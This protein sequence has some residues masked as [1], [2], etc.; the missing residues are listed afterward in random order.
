M[1]SFETYAHTKIATGLAI[2]I[3]TFGVAGCGSSDNEKNEGQVQAINQTMPA[4]VDNTPTPNESPIKVTAEYFSDGTR[5]IS[6]DADDDYTSIIGFCDGVDMVE[7]SEVIGNGDGYGSSN[8][9]RSA[10]HPAC[11]DNRLAPED[12][13]PTATPEQ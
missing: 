3:G 6:H 12:F 2:A 4:Q 13:E 7:Q 9:E 5:K 1:K 11:A 8:I 10:G